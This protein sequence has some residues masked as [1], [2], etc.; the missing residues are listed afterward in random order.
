MELIRG[1][2]GI[3]KDDVALAGGKGA[4]LG[5]MT[6]AGFPIP[7]GFVVLSTAFQ[8]FIDEADLVPEIES[9]LN[10]V[11]HRDMNSVEKA[12]EVIQALILEEEMPEDIGKEIM[13]EFSALGAEY[14]AVRSSATAEDS[15]SAA[16]AGQLNSY[17]NTTKKDLLDK[18]KHCWASLFTPRAI[19]YRF[20]KGLHKE[21]ISVAVVVQKMVQSDVSG[22]GFSVHPVTQDYDQLIIEA[23]FG[24]GE[25]IVSGQ[26]T[27]DSYVVSK[28]NWEMLE[29]HVAEQEKGIYRSAD[30]NEWKELGAKGK[31]QKLTDKE[32]L[33]LSKLM[34]KIEKHYGFPVDI[35]FAV[36]KGKLFV[37][38]SRPITTLT[39]EV[40]KKLKS[41]DWHKIGSWPERLMTVEIWFGTEYNNEYYEI[42]GLRPVGLQYYDGSQNHQFF[43]KKDIKELQNIWD[44]KPDFFEK[45]LKDSYAN[46]KKL[47]ET[48]AKQYS[49]PLDK[50]A[51]FWFDR[52][53]PLAARNAVYDWIACLYEQVV[54]DDAYAAY[55][56]LRRKQAVHEFPVLV[57][58]LIQSDV[59]HEQVA[60]A[61]EALL[62]KKG[63]DVKE[64]AKVLSEKYGYLPV[65]HMN[66]PHDESYYKELLGKMSKMPEK[67]LQEELE[68]VKNGLNKLKNSREKVLR[69]VE[70]PKE[71][72]KILDNM[73]L[74]AEMRTFSDE[75][76]S[77]FGLALRRF[78]KPFTDKHKLHYRD[79]FFLSLAEGRKALKEDKVPVDIIESRRDFFSAITTDDYSLDIL[80][81]DEAKSF[82]SEFLKE[83]I[84]DA[85]EVKG[86]VGY[87]GF[88]KGKARNFK[89]GL[90]GKDI[91]EGD[92]LVTPIT[93]VEFVPLMKKC[94]AIVTDQGG[95]TSHAAIVARELKKPCIVGTKIATKV[96]DE[97]EMIEVDADN[98]IVRK[99]E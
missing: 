56:E 52:V 63:K 83:E 3:S 50:Q 85:T 44:S 4:S 40:K 66:P 55:K 60:L 16:W 13:K 71:L 98:G 22:I 65:F 80:G 19:F 25:A 26:I 77:K 11:D 92:I 72:M 90:H 6:Q 45:S 27:P 53:L 28:K 33:E 73:R 15:A 94:A 99:L 42:A 43:L 74:C 95:L 5:E 46:R 14:V 88:V 82:V 59:T 8:R 37:T 2:S 58:P 38:Q 86:F 20:E 51:G 61:E 47:L 36:E 31:E 69:E 1:F 67:D 78:V 23:G 97:G 34:V 54:H 49:M 70:I 75:S 89:E 57:T 30:G 87:P 17:L 93:T 64:S 10:K 7:P 48:I 84:I 79:F 21:D 32:I 81:G 35:E 9:Q 18:V 68:R 24:L 41:E 96:F 12:A 76:V 39:S 62:V 91:D 29:K